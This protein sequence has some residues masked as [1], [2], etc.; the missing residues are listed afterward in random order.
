LHTHKLHT[1]L[2]CD[3]CKK[4][5]WATATQ[6]RAVHQ[7]LTAAGTADDV[8]N[9]VINDVIKIIDPSNYST[10]YADETDYATNHTHYQI[11]PLCLSHADSSQIT[12]HCKVHN[13]LVANQGRR[14]SD[15]FDDQIW[16]YAEF[17]A[18]AEPN[19]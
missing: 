4:E 5:V 14:I 17:K 16:D 11:T 15:S 8:I 9:D 19:A 18:L 1:D 6:A 12:K 2:Y 10:K 13:D 7:R 3:D